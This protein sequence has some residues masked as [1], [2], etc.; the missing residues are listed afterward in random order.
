MTVLFKST[1]F[2]VTDLMLRQSLLVMKTPTRLLLL[3]LCASSFLCL[4][5]ARADDNAPPGGAPPG[6]HEMRLPPGFGKLNLTD[7]QKSAILQ[8]IKDTEA[9]R[10]EKI[11]QVLTPDQKAQLEQ[12]KAE[13]HAHEDGSNGNPPP[14]AQ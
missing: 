3:G 8:I 1:D 13:H 5:T 14:P 7:A 11:D 6:S 9:E 12:M 2:V 4:Q 10:R